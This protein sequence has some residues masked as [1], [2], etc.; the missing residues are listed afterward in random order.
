[1]ITGTVTSIY[2]PDINTDDIIPAAFLQQSM[3]RKFFKDYAFD[4]YDPA[5]RERCQQTT[6]NIVIAGD[7]FGC[8]S[9]REQAVYAI[10]ENDVVCVIAQSYPDIF[11]RNSLSNGLV[12]ISLPDTSVFQ[13][14]DAL[15]VDLDTYTIEN[16]TQG[17]RFRF[18][19]KAD[20][21]ETFKQ[22]GMIG[23]VRSHLEEI[24]QTAK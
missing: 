16:V 15:R 22:G 13:A 19:M 4:K 14:G 2:G 8:G 6:T 12:L 18:E 24:L 10:K 11:Y 9:S 17:T 21:Q 3:D 23:R 20:D 7:N 5:F 1:M